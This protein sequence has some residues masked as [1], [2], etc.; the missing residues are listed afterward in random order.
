MINHGFYKCK[1]CGING[2]YYIGNFDRKIMSN[3]KNSV[4]TRSQSS[5]M[6]D[7]V[8]AHPVY[9]ED[10]KEIGHTNGYETPL[11]C[12]KCQSDKIKIIG[13]KTADIN[14]VKKQKNHLAAWEI[15]PIEICP[16]CKERT[17]EFRLSAIH[18]R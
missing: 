10:C 8:A 17:L 18:S 6:N 13:H 5:D 11:R 9:C 3:S 4:I 1:K 16:V 14:L 2:E 7:E 12:L 15:D